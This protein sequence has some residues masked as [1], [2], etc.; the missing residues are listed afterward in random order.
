M[1]VLPKGLCKRVL[2]T[3][4]S[5]ACRLIQRVCC[6][7]PWLEL[8]IINTGCDASKF[9]SSVACYPGFHYIMVRLSACLWSQFPVRLNER[10]GLDRRARIIIAACAHFVC[11][12][13][14]TTASD[15][16]RRMIYTY[17]SFSKQH[18]NI[19]TESISI[20]DLTS[21]PMTMDIIFIHFSFHFDRL[22][23]IK[24]NFCISYVPLEKSTL[25]K[26]PRWLCQLASC[27]LVVCLL[28]PFAMSC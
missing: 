18:R 12:F 19:S 14:W 8:C 16:S 25:C 21:K 2:S 20:F 17:N 9:G 26:F 15:I 1:L 27:V 10:A 28:S 13:R 4:L 22:F 24:N 7:Y 5:I 23:S 6:A 11:T 3:S